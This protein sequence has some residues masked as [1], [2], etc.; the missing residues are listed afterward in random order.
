MNKRENKRIDLRKLHGIIPK[1][2]ARAE[3]ELGKSLT[4]DKVSKLITGKNPAVIAITLDEV[5]LEVERRA[6]VKI[7]V[8]KINTQIIEAIGAL[9]ES[10]NTQPEKEHND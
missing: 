1:I 8:E 2:K 4:N 10:V 7:E 6:V 3:K 5:R 9:A